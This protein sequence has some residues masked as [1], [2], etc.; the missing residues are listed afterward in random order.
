MDLQ[1]GHLEDRY[2]ARIYLSLLFIMKLFLYFFPNQFFQKIA[3]F[4]FSHKQI[5]RHLVKGVLLQ[6]VFCKV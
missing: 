2:L 6:V 4:A 3:F 5:T 1:I